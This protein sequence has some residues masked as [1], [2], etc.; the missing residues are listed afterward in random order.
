[1]LAVILAVEFLEFTKAGNSI[2]FFLPLN[3]EW[4]HIFGTY[5]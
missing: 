5:L 1:M 2:R 3:S 4:E